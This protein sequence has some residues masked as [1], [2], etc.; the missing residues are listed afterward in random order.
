VNIQAGTVNGGGEVRLA[1]RSEFANSRDISLK[2]RVDGT[3]VRESP[4]A[5]NSNLQITGNAALSI[6]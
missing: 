2:L 5:Q 4:C 3:T 1:A 6:C